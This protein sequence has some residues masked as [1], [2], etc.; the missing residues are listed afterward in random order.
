MP[1]AE[2]S[3]CGAVLGRSFVEQ[4]EDRADL[5]DFSPST[6]VLQ[7]GHEHPLRLQFL[8]LRSKSAQRQVV[9][10]YLHNEVHARC[11]ECLQFVVTFC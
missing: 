10:L 1:P 8:P 2:A 11:E 5:L 4:L 9:H 7:T 6:Y 3:G